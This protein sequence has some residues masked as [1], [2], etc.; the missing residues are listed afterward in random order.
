MCIVI[1]HASARALMTMLIF[2]LCSLDGARSTDN[3]LTHHRL[4]NKYWF[5][6]SIITNEYDSQNALLK[7]K[8]NP[9][10]RLSMKFGAYFLNSEFEDF[11]GIFQVSS[12]TFGTIKLRDRDLSSANN[13]TTIGNAF[14][15]IINH[16]NKVTSD[17]QGGSYPMLTGDVAYTY[18]SASGK[19][20]HRNG[21]LTAIGLLS[22]IFAG[23]DTHSDLLRAHANLILKK[24]PA[25][26]NNMDFYRWYYASPAMFQM[27]GEYWKGWK[28]AMSETLCKAQHKG[29]CADGSWDPNISFG[30]R[31]GRLF[32]TALG[33]LTLEVYY[34][35]LPVSM[36]K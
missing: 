11:P 3:H 34:R 6:V 19:L 7:L 30:D 22:R 16:M 32:A 4:E 21:R 27:G 17:I 14:E 12:S 8:V 1:G 35:Y 13:R 24:L 15:G 29:G 2:D 5:S 9:A 20:G 28:D 18:N 36:L 33:C 10:D 31:G 25:Q 26:S 23:E